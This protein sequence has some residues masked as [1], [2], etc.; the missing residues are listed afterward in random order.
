MEIENVAQTLRG[1]ATFHYGFIKS[2][3]RRVE[4]GEVIMLS[5]RFYVF[6]ENAG[7]LPSLTTSNYGDGFCRGRFIEITLKLKCDFRPSA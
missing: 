5:P 4:R 7:G 2:S 1:H 6:C 3:S